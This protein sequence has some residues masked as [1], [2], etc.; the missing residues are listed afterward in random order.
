VLV[1][2]TGGATGS[3]DLTLTVDGEPV[4]ER[5][6]SVDPGAETTERF[7]HEFAESGEYEVRIGSETLTVAVTEP[8]PALVRGVATEPATVAAGESV[9]ATATVANDAGI[10]AGADVDFLVDGDVVGTESVRLDANAEATVERDVRIDGGVG[11]GS[12]TVSVVGPVDEAST[13]VEVEGNGAGDGA[14]DDTVP[15]FGPVV[16]VVAVLAALTASVA[17]ARRGCV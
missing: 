8:A 5:S 4:E 16:A 17:L 11:A 10:P 15:G 2:N 12:V 3:Y 9:R 1:S 13:T 6:G 7:G 14:T